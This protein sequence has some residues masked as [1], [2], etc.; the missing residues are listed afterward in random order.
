MAVGTVSGI[1]PNNWQLL[2]TITTP[3]GTTSATSSVT[4]SGYSTLM[5]TTSITTSGGADILYV[6]FN[7]DTG[8]NYAATALLHSDSTRGTNSIPTR[9]ITTTA[10]Q[11]TN[12]FI[13]Y[14]N[15]SAPKLVDIY[16]S[17][18]IARASWLTANALTSITFF[19][20]S[21]NMD[22][23]GTIKIYGIAG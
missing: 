17:G 23:G 20:N 2:E 7:G 19:T 16:S 10:L 8:N 1:S 18:G 11:N 12:V 15:I 4:L 14:A 9:T 6:R 22:S 3:G 21:N 5:C 13:Q